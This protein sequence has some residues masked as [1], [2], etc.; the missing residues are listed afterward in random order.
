M[1]Q[2]N[3]IT[4]QRWDD[5]ERERKDFLRRFGLSLPILTNC[6]RHKL[7][8]TYEGY[9]LKCMLEVYKDHLEV[10]E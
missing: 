5:A 7:T 1:Y 2:I 8:E 10:G 4:F 6:S 3:R 9:C